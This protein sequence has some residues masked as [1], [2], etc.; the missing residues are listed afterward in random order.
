VELNYDGAAQPLEVVALDG[1]PTGSQDGTARGKSIVFQHILIPPA[2]RAEFIVTAPSA[3]VAYAALRTRNVDT[4]PDG[5]NDPARPLVARE[6]SASARAAGVVMPLVSAHPPVARFAGLSECKPSAHRKLYF[7]EVLSNPADPNNPTNFFITVDGQTPRLFDPNNTPAIVT[8]QGAVEDWTIE[9]RA[10]ENHE[11]HIHQIHFLPLARNGAAVPDTQ[12]LD[13]VQ[14]P[15]WPG[16]GP[17]PSVKL[18]MDFRGPTV[19]DFVYHCHI[20]GHEDGGMMAIIRV[21]PADEK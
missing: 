21:K 18:R 20:L 15:Y 11:F 10:L 7:S 4:G 12:F 14:I 8:K 2:G 3:H 5:D 9:N 16:T 1:V 19:G 13:T 6:T 17:Y